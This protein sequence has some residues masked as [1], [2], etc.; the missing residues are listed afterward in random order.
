MY[1]KLL[2]VNVIQK[3]LDLNIQFIQMKMQ[4]NIYTIYVMSP[5]CNSENC[6]EPT[7]LK[8]QNAIVECNCSFHPS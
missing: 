4:K 2:T 8:I 6:H 1:N 5:I 7:P 3:N